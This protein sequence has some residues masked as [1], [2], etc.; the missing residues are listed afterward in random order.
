MTKTG[1][2]MDLNKK[3]K[4]L[5]LAVMGVIALFSLAIMFSGSG[6]TGYLSKSPKGSQCVNCPKQ[7]LECDTFIFSPNQYLGKTGN[8]V[9]TSLGYTTCVSLI[10]SVIIDGGEHRLEHAV[11]CHGDSVVRN[12]IV[13]EGNIQRG[14]YTSSVSCCRLR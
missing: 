13:N 2:L 12:N 4:A 5:V 6:G 3:S 9:C 11:P 10:E 8:H 14:W 7:T 1:D